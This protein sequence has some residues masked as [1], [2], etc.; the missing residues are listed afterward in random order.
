MAKVW[1]E[2]RNCPAI[3][4]VMHVAIEILQIRPKTHATDNHPAHAN[5]IWMHRH[6]TGEPTIYNAP[7]P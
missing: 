2:P 6:P 1:H 3:D 5:D 4:L 7:S